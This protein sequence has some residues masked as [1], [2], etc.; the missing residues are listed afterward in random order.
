MAAPT[1]G[2]NTLRA[3]Q[4]AEG[5]AA[6]LP[7]LLVAAERVAAT[8]AQGVHGRRRVGLGET[9]WQFR[10]YQPGD[11]PQM[12]DWRQSG[13]TQPVFVRE[14]EWEAA[15]TVW[16]WR[17]RSPSMDYRSDKELPT[18]RDRADLLTLATAVLL[19]RGGERV[20]LLNSGVRP[21]HG[22]FA[23]NRMAGLMT[24]P[25]TAHDPD[26]LPKP[27][28]LPRH[29][30]VVLVGDLLSPLPEIHACV[31]ALTGRGV[32]GHM[33][34]VLDPAEET[35][36]YDGRVEFEGFEGEEELLVP[37]VEAIRQ[38]YLERLRAQQDGLAALARAAGWTFAV[39]RTDRPPQSALLGLWGALA[40]EA[41]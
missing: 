38:T 31:S 29:A 39:H 30:Q 15:Q 14:N 4:R 10:R 6:T 17:D 13:K 35:L 19:V 5:L 12:I 32:R 1:L 9:F 3:Q 11:S 41:V 26:G 20:G 7:P 40:R 2:A 33:L 16:L 37:R 21:D 36:P 34:Q 8:V 25:R 23:L 18:K 24:D 28:P 27:E 22:K